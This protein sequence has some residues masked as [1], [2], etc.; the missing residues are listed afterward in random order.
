MVAVFVASKFVIS[1][2]EESGFVHCTAVYHGVRHVICV[3]VNYIESP[4]NYIESRGTTIMVLILATEL[5]SSS[6]S[7]TKGL[8]NSLSTPKC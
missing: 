7:F 8:R 2:L 3:C 4:A 6:L 1:W 5:R